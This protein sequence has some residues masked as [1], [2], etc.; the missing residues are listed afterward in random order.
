MQRARIMQKPV[1][2]Q[3]LVMVTREVDEQAGY[4]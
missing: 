3:S 1:T 4:F 2:S